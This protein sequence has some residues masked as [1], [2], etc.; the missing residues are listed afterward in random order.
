M[1]APVDQLLESVERSLTTAIDRIAKPPCPPI[2]AEA[3]R[4]AVFPPGNRARPTLSVL[5]ASACGESS[6]ALASDFGAAL[7]IMH[8]AS[9]VHDD[10][11][12]FDDAAARRG[13]ASVHRAFD[14]RTAVLAGDALVVVA[15]DVL[16]HSQAATTHPQ[17][18]GSLIRELSECAGLP[19]GVAAGQGWEHEPKVEVE[20]YHELKTAG[21]FQAATV[22]GAMSAGREGPPWASVG[23]LFG[24]AYQVADDLIDAAAAPAAVGKPTGKD[25][26]LGRPNIVSELGFAAALARFRWL[27]SEAGRA[28]PPGYDGVTL[29]EWIASTMQRVERIILRASQ[30]AA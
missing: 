13:K 29:R 2:L 1:V 23:R 22:G 7:E 10:L 25:R 18:L 19:R 3:V 17:L 27:V 8:C 16:S 26:D 28:V 4:Y 9:L 5:V 21:V 11:P 6:L 30:G 24:L 14:E 15:F 20:L 12:C